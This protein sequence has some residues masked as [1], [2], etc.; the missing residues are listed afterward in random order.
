M[1]AGR[2][3]LQALGHARTISSKC[4]ARYDSE[5]INQDFRPGNI[6]REVLYFAPTLALPCDA[7]AA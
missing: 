2:V 1:E 3:R 5:P 4:L 6:T 7:D